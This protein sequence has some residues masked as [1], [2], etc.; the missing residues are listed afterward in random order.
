MIITRYRL[1]GP[2]TKIAVVADLH[3]KPARRVLDALQKE[4]PDVICIPGDL[5]SGRLCDTDKNVL[6]AQQNALRFLKDC[7]SIAPTVYSRGNHER[8]YDETDI[9]A[10]RETGVYFPE[11][12]WM[13]LGALALGGLASTSKGRYERGESPPPKTAWL[14]EAPAGYRIV[15]CHHPEYYPLI[16]DKPIDLILAGHAHGG[17]WRFFG[18]G[19]FAPGQGLFP[20]Y[21][22]GIYGNMVVS[23]GLAN[24]KLIPRLWNPTELVILEIGE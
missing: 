4:K 17:Q 13:T 5:R 22:R 1:T 10:V 24:E 12:E 15:L 18:Q 2:K 23:A 8:N 9:A 19:I 14:S 6:S 21:T 11:N 20:K 7:A 16:S 3:D